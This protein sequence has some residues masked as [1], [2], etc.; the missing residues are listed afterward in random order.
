MGGLG[1]WGRGQRI[2]S[3]NRGRVSSEG[4]ETNSWLAEGRVEMKYEL[5]ESEN[6]VDD[7]HTDREAGQGRFKERYDKF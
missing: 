3:E 2:A 1:G 7:F 6:S 4:G 5:A